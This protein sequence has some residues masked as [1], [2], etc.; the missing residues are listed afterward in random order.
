MAGLG[1]AVLLVTGA[2][3]INYEILGNVE[4]ALHAHVI[5]RHTNED[6]G[7]AE[8]SLYGCMTGRRQSRM[9]VARTIPCVPAFAPRSR[10]ISNALS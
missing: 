6:S 9:A 1:D 10:L 8:S 4:P 2:E 3:R 5:P 7:T